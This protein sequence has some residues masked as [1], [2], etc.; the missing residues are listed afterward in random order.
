MYKYSLDSGNFEK[1]IFYLKNLEKQDYSNKIYLSEDYFE[2]ENNR[3]NLLLKYKNNFKNLISKEP[4]VFKRNLNNEFINISPDKNFFVSGYQPMQFTEMKDLFQLKNYNLPDGL[5][6]DSLRE[7]SPNG[8]FIITNLGSFSSLKTVALIDLEKDNLENLIFFDEDVKNIAWS[9]DS[10]EIVFKLVNGNLCKYNL[11]KKKKIQTNF[12]QNFDSRGQMLWTK[13]GKY[14]VGIEKFNQGKLKIFDSKTLN[15]VKVFDNVD[16]PHSLGQTEN[17]NFLICA[18]NNRVLHIWDLK[19]WSYKNMK[20]PSLVSEI[21][22]HPTEDK[23]IVN[24]WG[25]GENNITALIDIKNRKI[26]SQRDTSTNMFDYN[27]SKSGKE[28]IEVKNKESFN[29]LNATDLK[30]KNTINSEFGLPYSITLSHDKN[31]IYLHNSKGIFL[32]DLKTGKILN[33]IKGNFSNICK[34]ND[35]F[36]YIQEKNNKSYIY[37]L[38]NLLNPKEVLRLNYKVNQWGVKKNTIIFSG[39]PFTDIDHGSEIG[40]IELYDFSNFKL[41]NHIETKMV[42]ESLN[43]D[44]LYDSSFYSI[45]INFDETKL[46]FTTKWVDG[47]KMGDTF[48]K[49]VFVYDLKKNKIFKEFYLDDNEKN[50]YF[51]SNNS[52]YIDNKIYK[53][54]I[55]NNEMVNSII[56]N[57]MYKDISSHKLDSLSN[58]SIFIN[59]KNLK[60]NLE[61]NNI[62]V[63]YDLK[64]NKKLLSFI[65]GENNEMFIYTPDHYYDSTFKSDDN[66]MFRDENKIISLSK[67]RELKKKENL[68][69]SVMENFIQ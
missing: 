27:F 45:D 19:N 65:L 41:K 28:V 64:T 60:I 53:I 57:Y 36:I 16:W 51:V 40:F 26:V 7:I 34:F 5:Y 29:V 13:D 14:I 63:F 49:K 22:S 9:P 59:D 1:S 4:F 23:V 17:G 43:Y 61:S 66:I 3:I 50:I 48:S 24:D 12:K 68:F 55:E 32:I 39:T 52:I 6:Y 46:V 54:E 69:K 21:S 20:I 38:D 58:S 30:H 47:W 62:I 10:S 33:S 25:G 31:S 37:S 42:T 8:K 15:L 2:Y 18:D 11:S 44:Y 35:N 56:S 67:I